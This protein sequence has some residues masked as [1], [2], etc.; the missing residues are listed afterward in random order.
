VTPAS[1]NT[2]INSAGSCRPGVRA[3]SP[4]RSAR[5]VPSGATTAALPPADEVSRA[6]I[7][8]LDYVSRRQDGHLYVGGYN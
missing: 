6:R 2:A 5:I 4:A 3:A 8:F 1:L 7:T